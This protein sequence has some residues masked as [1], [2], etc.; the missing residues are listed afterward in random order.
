MPTTGRDKGVRGIDSADPGM[1][2]WILSTAMNPLQIP[3][4]RI[5]NM[6]PVRRLASA[7]LRSPRT[8]SVSTATAPGAQSA[9][10][11]AGFLLG[12]TRPGR[13]ALGAVR[14]VDSG[15]GDPLWTLIWPKHG[16]LR[17]LE[18]RFPSFRGL[19]IAET[20]DLASRRTLAT[21]S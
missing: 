12:C 17:P 20:M 19:S 5:L 9:R 2:S 21:G 7:S 1:H 13:A 3:A 14:S 6:S 18:P 4:G 8:G 15:V 10:H 16:W 11:G